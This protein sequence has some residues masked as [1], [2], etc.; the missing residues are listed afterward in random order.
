MSNHGKAILALA[1]VTAGLLL[2]AAQKQDQAE[3]AL[4]AAI[5]KELID[6]DLKA[7]IEMYKKILARPGGN[8]AAAAKALL[9]IG[10]CQEK[11]GN[12]EARKSYEQL[13]RD[14]PDQREVAEQARARLS[15]LVAAVRKPKFRKISI[16]SKLPRLGSGTL[17]PDGQ[18]LAFIADG[19]LWALPVHGEADPD[20]A[21]TP[22]RLT[23]PMHAWDSYG[24]GTVWS[25]D[26]QWIA[27]HVS[28]PRQDASPE[29]SI[30]IIPSSG[31]EP[32]S[33][34]LRLN[35]ALHG[36][37]LRFS[38][39]PDGKSLAYTTSMQGEGWAKRNIHTIA[40]QGGASRQLTEP[41]T[42]DPAFS[43]D[44]RKIAYVKLVDD[45]NSSADNPAGRQVWIAPLGGG[46]PVLVSGE[47]S[48][49]WLHSPVWSPDG[50]ML[51]FMVNPANRQAECQQIWIVPLSPEGRPTAPPAKIDLPVETPS[52]LAGW[53][54]DNRIG[55]LLP[56]P[57]H[58]ALYTVPA[59]GGRAVQVTPGGGWMPS[60]SPDGKRIYFDGAHLG[61]WASLE[62]VPAGGGKVARLPIRAEYPLGVSYPSGLSVSPDG[63]RIL[64]QGHPTSGSRVERVPHIF[65]I[66]AE[67]GTVTE[68]TTGLKWVSFPCWSPD[69]RSIAFIGQEEA[70]RKGFVAYNIHTVPAQGGQARKLTAE[71]DKVLFARIAWSPDG[72]FIAYFS[73][74][75][76]IKLLPAAGAS[77]RV[78]VSGV[79]AHMW[80]GLTWSPDGKEL[81]YGWD[82]R[83]WRVSLES[84]RREE[85]KTGVDATPTEIAW[86]P[87]GNTIA[88]SASQGGDPE[89]WLMEDFLPLARAKQ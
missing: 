83:I 38:L 74:D 86:S 50:K 64:F 15:T 10:Q 22:V 46:T 36:Y 4:R 6:G 20:I 66:G 16:P 54:Q 79:K 14:Y 33:V 42:A 84:G 23:K 45:P 51:A 81:A 9:H 48:A 40:V 41:G 11:L 28:E 35:S 2:A 39:S 13:L 58:T 68:I 56:T 19:S 21:G 34:P 67:G 25:G 29:R 49:G 60:W 24:V 44:G 53:T 8:R 3:V 57:R 69:G 78:L 7:A 43:P 65:T 32:R 52:V 76:T 89:L 73:G 85:V 88:F 37:Y 12:A 47:L 55:V 30:H 71:P 72:R 61:E 80:L 18:K 1:A 59:A 75:D 70:T 5:D 26:G 62:V 17:S 63:K 27:F 31:G 87:D 77:S 82:R